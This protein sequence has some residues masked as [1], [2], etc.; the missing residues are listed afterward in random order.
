MVVR[1][2]YLKTPHT[3]NGYFICRNSSL[4]AAQKKTAACLAACNSHFSESRIN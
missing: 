1:F 2:L 3:Q 4:F